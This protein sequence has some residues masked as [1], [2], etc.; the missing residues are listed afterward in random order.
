[1]I[2]KPAVNG[3]KKTTDNRF[4]NM[5]ELIAQ[6]RDGTEFPYQV[7]S[8]AKDIDDLTVWT[9]EVTA[10]AVAVLGMYDD[11]LVLIKQ[12]RYPIGDYIYELPAGLIDDGEDI[13]MAAHREM[14][15][16]TGLGF[17][18]AKIPWNV[19]PWL[20]SP[21]MTDEACVFVMGDCF[22]TPTNENQEDTEDIQVVFADKNEA[23]R[24]L[25]EEVV[26]VRTAFAIIMAFDIWK[27]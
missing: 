26:D 22:G 25:N 5:Y 11:K 2:N 12:Y 4:L 3:V 23:I 20:S 17:I 13:L 16:E 27:M 14:K 10:H 6:R 8:R 1:M 24:I 7:A 19:R 9:G 21:G 18:D 15:E